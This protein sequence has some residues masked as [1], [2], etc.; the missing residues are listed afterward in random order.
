MFDDGEGD[1][2]LVEFAVVV[3]GVAVE[4]LVGAKEDSIF[5]IAFDDF[6]EFLGDGYSVLFEY[7]ECGVEVAVFAWLCVCAWVVG[8]CVAWVDGSADDFD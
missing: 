6:V 8:G 5:A 1:F 2:E 7:F 4:E 3:I